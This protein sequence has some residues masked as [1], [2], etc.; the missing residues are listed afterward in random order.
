MPTAPG[1]SRLTAVLIG[2]SALALCT[3]PACKKHRDSDETGGASTSAKRASASAPAA[4]ATP[5]AART[6]QI[7]RH[8]EGKAS[9]V[10]LDKVVLTGTGTVVWMRLTND[11]KRKLEGLRTAPPKDNDAF[12]I[13]RRAD[14]KRFELRL[15]QGLPQKPDS[16]DLAVGESVTFSLVF[17]P[18]DEGMTELD[19]IEGANQDPQSTYWNFKDVKLQ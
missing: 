16:I 10:W 6:F 11:T 13:V 5:A 14:K 8:A 17:A 2:A 9:Y 12:Y 19:L 18:L 1:K 15:V 4:P 7:G 3:L